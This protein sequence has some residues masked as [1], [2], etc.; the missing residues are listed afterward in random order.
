MPSVLG[1]RRGVRM[2]TFSPAHPSQRNRCRFQKPDSRNEMPLTC[3]S[4][5]SSNENVPRTLHA[6]FVTS[7]SAMRAFQNSS[8][9]G[10]PPPCNRA[11]AGDAEMIHVAR[12][13]QRRNPDLK[14]PLDAR[15]Q[16]RII[17]NVR[18]T[19]Q[20][21]AL[22]QMQ[23]HAG[24]EINRARQK[25]ALG[26]HQRPA[27]VRGQRSIAFWMAAVLSVPAVADRARR[28]DGQLFCRHRAGNGKSEQRREENNAAQPL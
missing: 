26:N 18:R 27:A 20:H 25:F 19:L 23:I 1:E 4:F 24:L 7:R 9:N 28:R 17:C 16:F 22:V 5:E 14:M 2:S 6:R 11:F 15:H 8:Q 12:V 13:D 3:T 21:R 10:L